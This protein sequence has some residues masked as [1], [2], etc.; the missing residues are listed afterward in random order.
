MLWREVLLELMKVVLIKIR[1]LRRICKEASEQSK[2]VDI[3]EITEL[4]IK[5]LENLDG[6]KL[7]VVLRR[8][9]QVLKYV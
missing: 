3:P 6:I 8:I 2:R 9:F 1:T 5:D 7:M 4:K